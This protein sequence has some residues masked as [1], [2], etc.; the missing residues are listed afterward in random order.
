MPAGSPSPG[1]AL[2]APFR[3]RGHRS[4]WADERTDDSCSRLVGSARCP[5]A[6]ARDLGNRRTRRA[7]SCERGRPDARR[8][9]DLGA[10]PSRA[11]DRRLRLLVRRSRVVRT[12]TRLHDDRRR[13]GTSPHAKANGG[14]R[15]AR[16]SGATCAPLHPSA[17]SGAQKYVSAPRFPGE[18]GVPARRQRPGRRGFGTRHADARGAPRGRLCDLA[19]RS[20]RRPHRVRDLPDAA[21]RRADDLDDGAFPSTHARDAT[22]SA[23]VL[24]RYRDTL[25]ALS[26]ATD[27]TTRLEGDIWDPKP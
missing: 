10:H 21:A 26:A 13:S 14:S 3:A 19:V 15:R 4:F 11:A 8:D 25:G 2:R 12:R 22:V 17:A 18:V 16:R 5:G 9:R 23:R 24:W 6:A 1:R 7:R 20:A 27:A